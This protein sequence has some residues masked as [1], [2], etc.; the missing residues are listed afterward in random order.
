M[1]LFFRHIKYVIKSDGNNNKNKIIINI[2][3]TTTSQ[4]RVDKNLI[5]QIQSPPIAKTAE[6][7]ERA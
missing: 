7:S 5:T 1:T 2:S 6:P 3:S 4:N